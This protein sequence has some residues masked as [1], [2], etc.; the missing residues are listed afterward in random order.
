M[1]NKILLFLIG[2]VYLVMIIVLII[3]FW[4]INVVK[5]NHQPY[6]ILTPMVAAGANV[7]Y[8]VDACKYIGVRSTV[9]RTFADGVRYPSTTSSN[10]ISTG[11]KKTKVS[12]PV[13][14]YV[15][16]GKYHLDLDIVFQVNPFR[17]VSYHFQTESFQVASHSAELR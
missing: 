8:L 17:Q 11:C 3:L 10:N 16:A 2:G 12:I 5:T 14:N 7:T 4:P 1:T 9:T 15:P 13:P 6:K